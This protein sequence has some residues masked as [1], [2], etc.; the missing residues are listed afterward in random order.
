M[1]FMIVPRVKRAKEAEGRFCFD[2]LRIFTVGEGESFARTLKALLPDVRIEHTSRE[3]ANVVLSVAT[4]FSNKNEYCYLRILADRME[5]HVRDKEGA[6]NA[7][8]VLAQIMCHNGS[9]FSYFLRFVT[10]SA[11]STCNSRGLPSAPTRP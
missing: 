5:I 3:Q 4:V 1:S 2:T 10:A 9:S 7:A 6:R 11:F 8:C